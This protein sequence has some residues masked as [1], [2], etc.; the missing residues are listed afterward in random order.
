MRIP[1][2]ISTGFVRRASGGAYQTVVG[3]ID[4][5][6]DRTA[7]VFV[8]IVKG[9]GVWSDGAHGRVRPDAPGDS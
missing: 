7:F 3:D 5:A 9:N 6:T 4:G 8:S 2:T 1:R